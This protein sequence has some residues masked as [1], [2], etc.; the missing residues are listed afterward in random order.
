MALP[1]SPA[2]LGASVLDENRRQTETW[3]REALAELRASDVG[4]ALDTYV[5]Q[6]RVHQSNSD[7]EARRLPV[8]EW[9]NAGVKGE[10][11]LMVL[12]LELLGVLAPLG[13]LPGRLFD[14]PLTPM[15]EGRYVPKDI[16]LFAAGRSLPPPSGA[17]GSSQAHAQRNP[18][19]VRDC[20]CRLC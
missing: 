20:R 17:V 13:L 5:A 14:S 1:R 7:H 3:E 9:M 19:S 4:L 8:Q 6:N 15:I 16:I 12:G 10:N 11:V 18:P 2:T